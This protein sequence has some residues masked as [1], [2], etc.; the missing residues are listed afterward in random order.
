MRKE[1]HGELT[2]L[3]VD[4]LTKV[5]EL[6]EGREKNNRILNIEFPVSKWNISSE[7]NLAAF[8]PRCLYTLLPRCPLLR[9]PKPQGPGVMILTSIF[10]N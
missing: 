2:C 9:N 1:I 5:I 7:Q 4:R 10:T 3:Q 6:I 8:M